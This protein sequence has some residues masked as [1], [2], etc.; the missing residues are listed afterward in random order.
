MTKFAAVF[1]QIVLI[2]AFIVGCE[3]KKNESDNETVNDNEI[4]DDVESDDEKNDNDELELFEAPVLNPSGNIPLSAGID[5]KT[6][7]VNKINVSVK[8]ID[9]VSKDFEKEYVID[10]I[11]RASCRERV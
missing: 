10:K 9:G 2:F 3:N 6:E 7:G 5:I 11:G 1:F 8:D 4:T